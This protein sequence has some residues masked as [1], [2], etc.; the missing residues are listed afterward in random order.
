MW[1]LDFITKEDFKKHVANTIKTY[2]VTLESI[3][4]IKFNSNIIDPIKLTF[5]SKVYKKEIEE[6]IID[7]ILRQRD[8]TNTNAIGY[9]HQ[10]IFNYIKNCKIPKEGFDIIYTSQDKIVYVEMKN[11]HNTMNSSSSQKTYMKMQNKILKEENCEC[12]LVEVIATGSQNK[13][14]NVT[15]DGEK[16]SNKRIR[17]VS[18][19]KF[20]EE[21][22]GNKKAFYLV[23]RELSNIIDEIISE[24]KDKYTVKE[25]TVIKE[26]K[27]HNSDLLKSLYL[28]AFK[29]YEGFDEFQN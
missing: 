7:E 26:I 12:Y 16:F 20:Y 1:E 8:K 5:D 6:V 15:L 18:I 22:T 3:D 17:R 11:K 24:N 10:N 23:C 4:I 2:G 21:V 9:F 29:T 13:I 25:D 27:L 14:W 28:L 19:D